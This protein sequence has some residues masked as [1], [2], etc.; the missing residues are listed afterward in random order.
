MSEPDRSG[1]RLRKVIGAPSAALDPSGCRAGAVIPA[2]CR[3][4]AL[5]SDPARRARI[6]APSLS[7]FVARDAPGEVRWA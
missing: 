2:D 6:S 7:R 3:F 5:A 1:S 4:A